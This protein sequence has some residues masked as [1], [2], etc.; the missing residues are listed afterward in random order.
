MKR[1]PAMRRATGPCDTP[2]CRGVTLVEL[3][4]AIVV[5]GIVVAGLATGFAT[6][7]RSSPLSKEMHQALQLAQGRMELI[8]YQKQRLGFAGFTAATFDPC[9]LGGAQAAC[10]TP[11]GFTVTAS[12]PAAITINGDATNFMSVTITVTG[13]PSGAQLVQLQALV[14]N[15]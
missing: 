8:L 6:V 12:P 1:S 15:Y 7:T 2:R 10:Q 4:V 9:P 13:P 14:A 5:L 11:T 3:V